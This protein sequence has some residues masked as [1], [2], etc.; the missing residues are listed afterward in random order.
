MNTITDAYR[1]KC[2]VRLMYSWQTELQLEPYLKTE[3]VTGADPHVKGDSPPHIEIDS[4][5]PIDPTVD[6]RQVDMFE[7]QQLTL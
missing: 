5:I 2:S 4:I 3:Y 7:P 1:Y 6:G